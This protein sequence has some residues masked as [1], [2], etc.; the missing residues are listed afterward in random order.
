MKRPTLS[1]AMIV[2]NEEHNLEKL[3]ESI[4][5]CFDEIHIT[6]TGSTDGTVELAKKL[7]ATVHHFNWV[8]DFAKARNYSF[9]KCT[10]DYIMWMDGDDVLGNKEAFI[11]WRDNVMQLAN[12]WLA[13]YNYAYDEA[14]NP[15][16][17]FIRER[18][19]K[20]DLVAPW[21]YFIHEGMVPKPGQDV[22]AQSV[23]GWTINHVRG[24]A[25]VERDR[26]RNI[27][28]IERHMVLDGDIPNR[29]KFYYGKEL[30]D[31]GRWNDSFEV[32][33]EL[34][35]KKL[36]SHDRILGLQYF[37][38]V[39]ID[40]AMRDKKLTR[41]KKQALLKRAFSTCLQAITLEPKRAELHLMAGDCLVQMGDYLGS[42][43]FYHAAKGTIVNSGPSAL[44]NVASSTQDLPRDQLARVYAHMN[45]FDMAI[46]EAEESVNL[47]GSERSR[48]ILTELLRVRE[49]AEG[50]GL[51][52]LPETDEVVISCLPGSCPYP[53]DDI[54]YKE[55]GIGGSET[56]AVE[57]AENF[58][59]NG[60]KVIVFNDRDTTR[61]S[62]NGVEYRSN[63][64]MQNYF[65]HNK[66]KVHIAW[67]HNQKLT[68]AKT[69]L[70]CHDLT[71]R[72][73][74]AHHVYNKILCL[75]EFHK[76]YV[77]IMQGIPT[78]KIQVTRNGI[79]PTRFGNVDNVEKNPYS[80]VFPSSPDRGLD[81]AINICE[82]AR[83]I[84]GLPIELNVF[85]GFDNLRKYGMGEMADRLE[86]ACNERDWINYHGNVEQRVLAGHM[87]R[88][89]AW[90]YPA[91]FIETFCITAIEALSAK[92][93]PVAREIGAL[94]N[95]LRGA[96]ESGMADLIFEDAV[97]PK[98]VDMW[99]E[100]LIDA[101]E[102]EKWKKIDVSGLDF[103]WESVANEFMEF[104][105]LKTEECPV[106]ID[107][108]KRELDATI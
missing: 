85:Y 105:D 53:W 29:L 71:T 65:L 69:F 31:V 47:Y 20:R 68:D 56:A 18:V 67:R 4:E 3:F 7:G 99:A 41:T 55:K 76:D 107:K 77:Q 52:D 9:S 25:D 88:S 102:Q 79:D 30:S 17:D 97:T 48:E 100:A 36:E 46:K 10:T 45:K 93:Y 81:R 78:E 12:F 42:L 6:D 82:R 80:V 91:D 40:K 86:R 35:F 2:K 95:T 14:G 57:I 63:A 64:A 34:D 94:K 60:Q 38:R 98:E 50:D 13:K 104:M 19:I 62:P 21:T 103:S 51:K 22:K 39:M 74:E 90:L 108:S 70:W 66:P 72:G 87:M 61:V 84:S 101:I 89:S 16:I 27:D 49:L 54:I 92:C 44:F 106:I 59:K 15:V 1:L 24:P 96:Y 75:T 33:D 5:G 28:I 83:E 26:G 73:A 8:D 11:Q 43:P 23:S 37:V 32:F 58:A